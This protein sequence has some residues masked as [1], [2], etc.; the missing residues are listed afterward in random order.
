MREELEKLGP[1]KKKLTFLNLE[2]KWFEGNN[3][4]FII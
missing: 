4:N 3:R 1:R 2:K